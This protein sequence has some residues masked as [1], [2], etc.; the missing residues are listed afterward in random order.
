MEFIRENILLNKLIIVDGIGK[1]GKS[2]MLDLISSFR[3]VEKKDFNPFLEYIGL[4]YKYNKISIDMATA[5]LKTE[6]DSELYNNMIGRYINTRLSDDTSLY[7]YHSPAKYIE[8]SLAQ[9]GPVVSKKVLAENPIYLCWSHDLINKSDIIFHAFE[10]RLEWIYLNRRPIDIIYEWNKKNYS[11]RMSKD[12]TEMQYSI[13]YQ[14]TCVPEV[15]L[16]WEQEFLDIS[17]D[18]R[19]VKMIH[20]Y[21]KWNREALF[22]KQDYSNLHVINF[23][24]LVTQPLREIEKLKQIIGN[25]PLPCID[26]ILLSANCPRIINEHEYEE[27]ETN[28][29][30]NISKKYADLISE[31]KLMYEDIKQ[32]ATFSIEKNAINN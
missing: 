19:T 26:K 5:I 20:T 23:E 21:F 24:D 15:A 16:G 12:P 29:K 4:A 9:D 6:M 17:P 1:C 31:I 18:E 14:N 25:K 22:K 3:S 28:I 2:I 11:Q 10:S 7:K 32:L 8:R 30:K 27:R 13:K